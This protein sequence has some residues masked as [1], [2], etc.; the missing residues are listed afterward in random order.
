MGLQ[1]V[2]IRGFRSLKHVTWRPEKLNIVIGPNGSGKSNLLRA[3]ALLQEGA[4]GGLPDQVLRQG[5]I[6]PLL[7]DGESP[8]LSWRI[9][10]NPVKL[11]HSKATGALAYILVLKRLGATS[12][13]RV[14]IEEL[15]E[16]PQVE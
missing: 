1:E 4:T 12:S 6:A 14:E 10:T 5:G 11:G 15:A 3:I 16:C 9:K 8:E 13:Y 2:E 7:W